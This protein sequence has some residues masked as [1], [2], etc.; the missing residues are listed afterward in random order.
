MDLHVFGRS[1]AGTTDHAPGLR[2]AFEAAYAA[3][4]DRAVLDRLREIEGRGRY[5]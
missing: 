1:L 2:E 3:V 4:G 5:R